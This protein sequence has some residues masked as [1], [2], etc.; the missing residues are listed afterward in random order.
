ML[1]GLDQ[2]ADIT[3]L[4]GEVFA[5]APL[6]VAA[7]N[8]LLIGRLMAAVLPPGSDKIM[9]FGHR[10]YK[11]ADPRA[12]Y[13]TKVAKELGRESGNTTYGEIADILEGVMLERKKLSSPF[14][15]IRPIDCQAAVN[16][17]VNCVSAVHALP[18]C[19]RSCPM[20][21]TGPTAVAAALP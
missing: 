20:K 12:Q 1:F 5:A 9:G 18:S 8:Y 11:K 7:G 14:H 3:E 15:T 13:M 19:G 17:A 10:E 6:F 21:L 2:P 4:E 16:W